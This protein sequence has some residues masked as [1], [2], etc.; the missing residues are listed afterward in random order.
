M[1]T[2]YML[3]KKIE[4]QKNIKN[5]VLLEKRRLLKLLILVF[6]NQIRKGLFQKLLLILKILLLKL[7]CHYKIIL[8]L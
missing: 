6:Q 1:W 4:L 5:M 2:V 7:F 3:C 8:L